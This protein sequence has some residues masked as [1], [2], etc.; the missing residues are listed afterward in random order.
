MKYVAFG[1]GVYSFG[2]GL[3]LGTH[4]S[5]ILGFGLGCILTGIG[6]MLILLEDK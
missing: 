1:L 2:A 6:V 3:W 4:S 5:L